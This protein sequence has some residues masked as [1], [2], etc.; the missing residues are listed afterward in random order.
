MEIEQY[1]TESNGFFKAME[2]YDE[3]GVMT[4]T[5]ADNGNMLIDHTE[6]NPSFSGKGIGTSLVMK[7]VKY[8]RE[9]NV[10]IHP[11]CTF[12]KSVFDSNPDLHDVLV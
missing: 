9:Q 3:A 5:W 1:N 6:T 8:A 7:A 10:K 11:L 4:Y 2:G 12:A